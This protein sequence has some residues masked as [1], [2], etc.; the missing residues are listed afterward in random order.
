MALIMVKRA[1]DL[2]AKPYNGLLHYLHKELVPTITKIYGE[3]AAIAVLILGLTGFFSALFATQGH[4]AVKGIVFDLLGNFGLAD[5]LNM[6]ASGRVAQDFGS[7]VEILGY[8]LGGILGGVLLSFIVL[9]GTYV[10]LEV[11]NYAVLLITNLVKFLPRFAFP[12]WLQKS[13]R[14]GASIDSN[15]L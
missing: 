10:M 8:G 1:N 7:Y 13:E 14:G 11:Y 9:L 6:L 12:I 15:D 4:S 5:A 2:N 3:V